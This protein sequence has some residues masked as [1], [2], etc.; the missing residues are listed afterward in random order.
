[1]LTRKA[2]TH[3]INSFIADLKTAGYEP[4]KVILFGSYAAGQP[5]EESDIDLAVWDKRFVGLGTVDIVP[6]LSIISKYPQLE[7]HP[8]HT[9]ETEDDNPFIGEITRLGTE[10]YNPQSNLHIA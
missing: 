6:I 2:L 8:F 7:L 10:L 9:D 3:Y 4:T 1:M 5:H